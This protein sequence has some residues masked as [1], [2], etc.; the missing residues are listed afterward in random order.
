MDIS[1]KKY[2]N[3]S[4]LLDGNIGVAK[5]IMHHMK[6][7]VRDCKKS[8]ME[9]Y[10]T[11]LEEVEAMK[12]EIIEELDESYGKELETIE[13][14]ISVLTSKNKEL[15]RVRIRSLCYP[16]HDIFSQTMVIDLW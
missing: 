5:K 16:A 11:I 12:I 3:K 2:E 7:S 13:T 1:L 10:T 15:K 9:R 8:I 6:I 14:E 4:I